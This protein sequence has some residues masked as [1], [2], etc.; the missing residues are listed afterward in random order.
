M[1]TR[2]GACVI[3]IG[4]VANTYSMQRA[5]VSDDKNVIHQ[6]FRLLLDYRDIWINYI[7]MNEP[8]VVRSE[9]DLII[10]LWF[11]YMQLTN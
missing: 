7:T 9:C 6:Y 11:Y 8:Y 10:L 5:R 4:D 3:A 1:P 2:R